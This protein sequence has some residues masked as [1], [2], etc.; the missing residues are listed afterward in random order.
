MAKH[1]AHRLTKVERHTIKRARRAFKIH[2]TNQESKAVH[3]SRHQRLVVH[4]NNVDWDEFTTTDD[5]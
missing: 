3:A 5:E 2:G 1:Y 4:Y